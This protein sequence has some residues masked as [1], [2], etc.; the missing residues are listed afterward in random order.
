[1]KH[2][3]SRWKA[4]VLTVLGL[5]PVLLALVTVVGAAA[6]GWPLFVRLALV[7]PPAVA[8]TVWGFSPIQQ[9]ILR[10]WS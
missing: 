2:S 3:P 1:M 5:Y 6:P 9:H 4:W 8:W 7:A 10:R